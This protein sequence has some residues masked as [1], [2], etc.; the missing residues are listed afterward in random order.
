VSTKKTL[1]GSKRE[2]RRPGRAGWA[3][4]FVVFRCG[5]RTLWVL[6]SWTL[7]FPTLGWTLSSVTLYPR[8]ACKRHRIKALVR[9]QG[10]RRVA[11]RMVK[12]TAPCR[13]LADSLSMH[14]KRILQ[15]YIR[16][17]EKN[18]FALAG[19]VPVRF[20]LPRPAK[21]RPMP[22]AS[23]TTKTATHPRF[24]GSDGAIGPI[25]CPS[26]GVGLCRMVIYEATEHHTKMG[27]SYR[28]YTCIC[29][30]GPLGC[31]VQ[32]D[33]NRQYA[34]NQAFKYVV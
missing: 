10:S 25:G 30:L 23:K 24:F 34:P 1:A 8:W 21:H 14:I 33:E 28:R 26:A 29:H 7:C 17:N 27:N 20:A 9:T 18:A 16:Q 11:V 19:T 13:G 5:S 3:G 32:R 2:E 12:M 6:T 31:D 22:C 15:T 4:L